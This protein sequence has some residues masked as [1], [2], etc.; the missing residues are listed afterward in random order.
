MSSLSWLDFSEAD[1]QK[2]LDVI[3]LFREKGTVEELGLGTVRDAI[4]D[5]LFPGTSTIMTRARYY[6]LIPWIYLRLEAKKTPSNQ[7][8]RAA[9]RDELA[10]IEA[11]VNEGERQGVIGI[12]ARSNLRRLPSTI[13]WSGLGRLGIRRYPGGIDGYHRSLDDFYKNG[14]NVLRGDDGNVVSGGSTRNWDRDLPVAPKQFLDGTSLRLEPLEAEY[15]RERI[16]Q[17]APESVFAFLADRP[18]ETEDVVFPWEHP[19]LA[20]MTT[21]NRSELRHA[22]N[23]SLVMFGAA[24]LYNL[25]LAERKKD[26]ENIDK[27]ATQYRDWCDEMDATSSELSTW[28]RQDFWALVAATEARISSGTQRFIDAWLDRAILGNPRTLPKSTDARDLITWRERTLKGPL[29]RLVDARALDRWG[30]ASGG[31][32]LDYRWRRPVRDILRDLHEADQE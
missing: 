19:K 2:A 13:Y 5:L 18:N 17:S 24:L 21:K 23:F 26:R 7:I 25:M 9:H 11:L 3:D 4:A 8:G 30:G 6:L 31:S 22:G 15:L 32:R 20:K 12:Q 10:L 14:G 16:I 27:Y 28:S 29:A 1:R